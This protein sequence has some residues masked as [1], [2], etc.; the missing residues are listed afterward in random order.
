M[1]A[2]STLWCSTAAGLDCFVGVDH[3]CGYTPATRKFQH[4]ECY[5]G[6]VLKD[7]NDYNLA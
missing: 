5:S 4:D 7:L 3:E 2:S 6:I 1:T